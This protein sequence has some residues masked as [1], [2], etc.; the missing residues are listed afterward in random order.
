MPRTTA[1]PPGPPPGCSC[2]AAPV[3]RDA[4]HRLLRGLLADLRR[5][6]P[7]LVEVHGPP[8]IGRSTLLDHAAALAADAGVRVA[9]AA[10]SPEETCLP[11]GITAQLHSQLHSGTTP[12][13]GRPDALCAAFLADA[14]SHPFLLVVDDL[15]WA[16]PPS[17]RWLQALARRLTGV[18]LML[19]TSR[20]SAARPEPYDRI[21]PC[22][23]AGGR[24]VARHVL[25]LPPL[26]AEAVHQVLAGTW[27]GSVDP[28]FQQ[29]AARCLDGNPALL[30]SVVSRFVRHGWTPR[31]AHLTH[32]AESAAEAVR[33]RTV[34]TLPLLPGELV[35]VLRAMAV[36]GPDGTPGLIDALAAGPRT[37]GTARALTLLAGTGLLAD[38]PRPALRSE[39]AA[40]AVLAELGTEQREELHA[41][42]AAWAHRA[43]L[44]DRS[45]ARMLLDSGRIGAPWAVAALRRRA[46]EHRASGRH[47]QAAR[48]LE[49]ALREPVPEA[50][51]VRLLTELGTATL[52]TGAEAASRHLYR[53]LDPPAGGAGSAPADAA[54]VRARLRAAELLVAR[55][56]VRTPAARIARAVAEA[57]PGTAEHSGLRALYWMAEDGRPDPEDGCGPPLPDTWPARPEQA[58]EAAVAAWRTAQR[59]LDIARAR[60]LARAALAPEVR[61]HVPPA[62]RAAAAHALVLSGD[63]REA[64]SA[65][66]EVLVCARRRDA[67]PVAGAALLVTCVAELWGGRDAAASEALDR[68]EEVM[69]GRSWHPLMAPGPLALRALLDL[70]RGDADAAARI[71]DTR[72][73]PVAEGGLAWAYL[74]YARGRVRL[75]AGDRDGALA[76]LLECGRRLLARQAANPALLPWRSAAARTRD[77]ED[78]LA[79]RLLA[80]ERRRAVLWGSPLALATALAPA[81]GGAAPPGAVARARGRAAGW[82][83]RQALVALGTAP[84][85][86]HL[87]V[88]SLLDDD[89]TPADH[90]TPS[91]TAKGP[92]APNAAA[93]ARAA[94]G[95]D[96]PDAAALA[97]AA[98]GPDVPDAAAPARAAM[99]PDVPDAAAPALPAPA[100]TAPA[101]TA[102]DATGL[103]PAAMGPG[104]PVTGVPAPTATGPAPHPTPDTAP[105]TRPARHRTHR[106]TAPGRAAPQ[107]PHRV[108]APA[109]SGARAG[110]P[111]PAAP[112]AGAARPAR[113]GHAPP[114]NHEARPGLVPPP[115]YTA[116]AGHEAS[117]GPV[118]GATR[119]APAGYPPSAPYGA[120]GGAAV[121]AGHEAPAVSAGEAEY[122]VAGGHV[123]RAAHT[124]PGGYVARAAHQAVAGSTPPAGEVAGPGHAPPNG[125][126]A[127]AGYDVPAGSAGG[128]GYPARVGHVGSAGQA[129]ADGRA[130]L[131]G[132]DV[133]GGFADGAGHPARAGHVAGP[134]QAA[135]DGHA[136][137]AAYGAPAGS[138]GG[139][140]YPAPAGYADRPGQPAPARNPAPAGQAGAAGRTGPAAGGAVALTAAESR[141]AALAAGGLPNRAIAEELAVTPRTVEQHLTKAYRKL[142]IRG[143]PQLAAALERTATEEPT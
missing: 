9:V 89:R 138:A 105:A 90:P 27:P 36:A 104:L 131:A 3:G 40:R 46:D 25:D 28:V 63:T 66:D 128:A 23:L 110:H 59:G 16:D 76:D 65:L 78:P 6:R 121:S 124:A 83:Y 81:P 115:G 117:A 125:P 93:L 68:C 13:P 21:D 73:P 132:Y 136:A 111:T 19:L 62:V 82:Q 20:N 47:A 31:T 42:A 34:R 10:A 52:P 137:L 88:D 29:Q 122:P 77:P 50:L 133:P 56:D 1:A 33:E 112:P 80:E 143:R 44:P 98:M 114:P 18:P 7:A 79:V 92:A 15:Q 26:P 49:R 24:T 123:I 127:L 141:V 72:L 100:S 86:G 113:T 130:V 102:P 126:A 142:G 74:L 87:T 139:A 67:R 58:A 11:H 37:P 84:F 101:S 85:S 35:G 43:A 107:D 61:A 140:G 14:R 118:A 120:P 39:A 48:L 64:R 51:R 103:A 97:R 45:V 108:P 129:A 4:E 8:G 135:P 106:P 2:P 99:G 134:G 75:A 71:L 12:P 32:L 96:V 60:G 70:R 41:R 5:G 54:T 22:P 95:P 119:P 109:G 17:L 69:P 38:G 91:P 57:A 116:P 30:R 55:G 53:A 94:M